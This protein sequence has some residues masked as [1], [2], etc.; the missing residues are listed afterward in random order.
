MQV[1]GE[2]LPKKANMPKMLTRNHFIVSIPIPQEE[3]SEGLVEDKE[4]KE[5]EMKVAQVSDDCT[6]LKVGDIAMMGPDQVLRPRDAFRIGT[7]A[8]YVYGENDILG[9]W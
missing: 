9:V 8:Y 7:D 4:N 5:L 3:E 1:L 6:V 2:G